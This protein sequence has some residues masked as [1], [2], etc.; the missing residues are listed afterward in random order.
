MLDNSGN[1]RWNKWTGLSTRLVV[2]DTCEQLMLTDMIKSDHS[3]VVFHQSPGGGIVRMTTFGVEILHILGDV[4]HNSIDYIISEFESLK[5]DAPKIIT[6]THPIKN[7]TASDVV[8][9]DMPFAIYQRNVL[10][11]EVERKHITKKFSFLVNRLDYYRLCTFYYIYN[12]DLL[13]DGAV[14]F[15]GES[16]NDR[17]KQL[18]GEGLTRL[19]D[20]FFN[21]DNFEQA[22]IASYNLLPFRNFE[23][24]GD[25]DLALINSWM[26]GKTFIVHETYPQS[27]DYHSTFF[28]S[29]KTVLALQTPRPFVLLACKDSIAKLRELGFNLFDDYVNHSYDSEYATVARND[30]AYAEFKNLILNLNPTDYDVELWHQYAEHNRQILKNMLEPK[31]LNK[32]KT[33]V[34]MEALKQTKP[35]LYSSI[36]SAC[37]QQ[38]GVL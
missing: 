11:S 31:E 34:F 18:D 1:I 26:V 3:N 22:V 23:E 12:D 36:V 2:G 24:E 16:A 15:L 6:S 4:P 33:K 19:N 9:F 10:P 28:F 30:L 13:G 38:P 14:S 17:N 25:G 8:Y 32:K 37:N 20:T 5:T 29:E 21:T 35:E 7:K 27:D